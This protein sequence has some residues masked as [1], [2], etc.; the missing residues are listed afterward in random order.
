MSTV[1]KTLANFNMVSKAIEVLRD[2]T[3]SASIAFDGQVLKS[4]TFDKLPYATE[5]HGNDFLGRIATCQDELVADLMSLA[6]DMQDFAA[7]ISGAPAPKNWAK[8][9]PEKAVSDALVDAIKQEF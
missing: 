7:R 3:R 1:D 9:S 8:P 2:N 4:Q 6:E 5:A